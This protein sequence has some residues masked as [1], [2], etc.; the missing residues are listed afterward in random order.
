MDDL[1]GLFAGMGI[2][3]MIFLALGIALLI[4]EAFVAGFGAFGICGIISLVVGVI[5]RIIDG[6]NFIQILYLLA[7]ILIL[8]G[9]V[10]LLA[11]F[12]LKRGFLS[13]TPIVQNGSA[14]PKEYSDPNYVYGNL[15][16]KT[17]TAVTEC[18]PVG[19]AEIEGVKYNV[20]SRDGFIIKG[21][22][23]IVTYVEGEDIYVKKLED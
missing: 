14:V 20:I 17:G 6:T 3:A 12:S 5:L 8:V 10:F 15:L 7:L 13:K 9:V 21:S 23:I 2:P 18:H 22:K 19:E 16:Q 1:V 4:V 11:F